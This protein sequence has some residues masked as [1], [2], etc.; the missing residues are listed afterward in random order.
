MDKHENKFGFENTR[1][2]IG[3]EKPLKKISYIN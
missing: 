2:I 1:E 3:K